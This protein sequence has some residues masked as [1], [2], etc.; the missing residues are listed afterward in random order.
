MRVLSTAIGWESEYSGPSWM[1]SLTNSRTWK[2]AG[3]A[4]KHIAV[5][6]MPGSESTH[7]GLRDEIGLGGLTI[8]KTLP[9]AMRWAGAWGSGGG[10]MLICE[11]FVVWMGM[12]DE[13]MADMAPVGGYCRGIHGQIQQGIHSILCTPTFSHTPPHMRPMQPRCSGGSSSS[14]RPLSI[15]LVII[16]LLFIS[17]PFTS[18]EAGTPQ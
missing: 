18:E 13:T 3:D 16:T 14:A 15:P 1:H 7:A 6:S 12:P 10:G 8:S 17:R 2:E 11:G 9:M 5:S 4:T